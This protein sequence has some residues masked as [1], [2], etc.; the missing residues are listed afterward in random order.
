[1]HILR[2]D[3]DAQRDQVS[4]LEEMQ[5]DLR[6]PEMFSDLE[7]FSPG[8]PPQVELESSGDSPRLTLKNLPLYSIVLLKQ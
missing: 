1:V 6:L 2:Y 5:L 7:V 4:A 8:E 3:Y